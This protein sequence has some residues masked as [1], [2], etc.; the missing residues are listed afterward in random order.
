MKVRACWGVL[1]EQAEKALDEAQQK[2]QLAQQNLDK[3]ESSKLRLQTMISEYSEKAKE[4]EAQLHSVSEAHNARQFI[5]QLMQLIDRVNSDIGQAQANLTL[6]EKAVQAAQLEKLK[7][8]T[9]EE[10]DLQAV[11]THARKQEQK[12][13]D[14]LGLTLFNTKAVSQSAMSA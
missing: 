5:L 8:R 1:A 10:Q 9:L 13:M 2:K 14:A 4:K 3:L 11:K 12:Q 7:M 6:A